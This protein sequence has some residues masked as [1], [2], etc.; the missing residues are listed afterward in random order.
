MTASTRCFCLAAAI[1]G[2][3][4]VGPDQGYS[5]ESTS[6]VSTA[7]A[8]DRILAGE[9]GPQAWTGLADAL[10]SHRDSDFTGLRTPAERLAVALADSLIGAASLAQSSRPGIGEKLAG[11]GVEVFGR[12]GSL[13]GQRAYGG[14]LLVV[15][16][17][18][19][20]MVV[21]RLRP[22]R[23]PRRG[24]LRSG[25]PLLRRGLRHVR[26]PCRD[27][28]RLEARLRSRSAA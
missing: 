10:V 7:A 15:T 11:G 28:A 19:A 21:W 27:A 26:P 12:I 13:A 3:T 1:V 4:V 6:S 23:S 17:L 2:S 20:I 16:V 25:A 24:S 8:V 5:Q 9:D 22:W 18:S 14:I